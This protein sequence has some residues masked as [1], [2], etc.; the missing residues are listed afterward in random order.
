M[1]FSGKV[2]GMGEMINAC[3]ILAGK[4]KGRAPLQGCKTRRGW[5]FMLTRILKKRC[6]VWTGFYLLSLWPGGGLL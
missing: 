6:E 1:R 3:R 5:K 2:I 4:S